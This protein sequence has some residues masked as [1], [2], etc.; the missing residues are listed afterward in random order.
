MIGTRASQS[1]ISPEAV[2]D[3]RIARLEPLLPPRELLGELA[4]S[5]A[6]TETVV[7]G[8]EAVQA[9]LSG[10]DDRLLA[11]V[12]PCSVHDVDATLDYARRLSAQAREIERDVCVVMR[13]YF[14]K[15]RTT[16]G[17]KGLINDP[18]L[19]GSFA[20]NEGLRRARRLL[21][22]LAELG[23]PAG[24]E[25]LDSISPQYTSDL[26]SWGAIGPREGAKYFEPSAARTAT[27]DFIPASALMMDEYCLKC[28]P[29]TY[30][31]H[32][33]SA[34]HFSSFNNPPYR[35]SVRESRKILDHDGIP[36]ASRW[37]AGC[38]DPEPYF[39]GAFDDPNFDDVNHPTAQAGITCTV[40]HAITNVNSPKGNADFTIVGVLQAKGHNGQIDLDDVVIVPFHTGQQRLFGYGNVASILLQVDRTDNIPA[41]AP[42]STTCVVALALARLTAAKYSVCQL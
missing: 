29:D 23:L 22:D 16:T 12:G 8:R 37:G 20:I 14:E 41:V 11:V 42:G 19:D 15:P 30:N 25:F 33:H 3:R 13:V 32:F 6:Q 36:R 4:L 5:E 39:S 1:V 10:A 7:R 21:L 26:V 9:I 27:G 34:H 17:W 40:C 31:D 35:F 28:H 18:R 2:R 38:H 24:C